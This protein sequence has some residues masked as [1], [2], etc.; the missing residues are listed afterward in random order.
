MFGT[1]DAIEAVSAKCFGTRKAS[2]S[3]RRRTHSQTRH[4]L[5]ACYLL[6]LVFE[7]LTLTSS[8]TRFHAVLLAFCASV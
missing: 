3:Y 2:A 8:L 7:H 5:T 1:R 6:T 4:G